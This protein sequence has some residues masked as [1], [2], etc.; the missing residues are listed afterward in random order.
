MPMTWMLQTML[1][2]LCGTTVVPKLGGVRWGRT[3]NVEAAQFYQS[4][5]LVQDALA[6]RYP[7]PVKL[8]AAEVAARRQSVQ[9]F[10]TALARVEKALGRL[11]ARHPSTEKT[12]GQ[13]WQLPRRQAPKLIGR[14]HLA[15][16]LQKRT[17]T[18]RKARQ[19][20]AAIWE[21]IKDA[22]KRGEDVETPLGQFHVVKR[23]APRTR[24]RLGQLQHLYRRR[25]KV[26]FTAARE[27]R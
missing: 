15:L 23:P 10:R 1:V 24:F 18:F 4:L 22:L 26:V 16:E 19:V 3:P 8:K 17:L 11:Q 13:A 14:D 25:K 9:A 20:V 27:V 12:A 7:E 6:S 21:S 2:C 5:D